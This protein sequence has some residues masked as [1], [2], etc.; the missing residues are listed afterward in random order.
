M[1]TQT[2]STYISKS[3][4]DM[5]TFLTTNLKFST[6]AR[7]KKVSL[8]DSNNER[9]PEMAAKTGNIYIFE[10]MRDSIEIPTANLGF[11]TT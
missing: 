2:G 3:I 11:T 10:T 8:G 9:Q 4:T 5:S 6:T 7:S 1:A